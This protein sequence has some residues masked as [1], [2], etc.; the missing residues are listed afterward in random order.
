MKCFEEHQYFNKYKLMDKFLVR[1]NYSY[2]A[3]MIRIL[4]INLLLSYITTESRTSIINMNILEPEDK[5]NLKG[6]FILWC[7]NRLNYMHAYHFLSCVEG[8]L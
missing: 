1:N 4:N 5:P 2:R 8:E 7:L 6:L 3:I